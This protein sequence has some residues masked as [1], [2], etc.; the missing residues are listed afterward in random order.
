MKGLDKVMSH[1]GG[2]EV[3]YYPIEWYQMDDE[4]DYEPA[5][6]V[7]SYFYNRKTYQEW[8]HL[9]V[10]NSEDYDEEDFPLIELDYNIFSEMETIFGKK[11]IDEFAPDFFTDVVGGKVKR[12]VSE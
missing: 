3:C 11:I 7:F 10:N 9:P 12:V 5:P 8:H 2:Y 1:G 4:G 6:C